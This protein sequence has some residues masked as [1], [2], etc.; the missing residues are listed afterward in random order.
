[1]NHYVTGA[2]IKALREKQDMTQS[3]LAT[4]LCVSDKTISKWETGRGFPDISLIEALAS[5]LQVS[6]PELLS[7][8]QIINTNRS[9]NILRSRIYVCPICGNILHST[10]MALISCCGI[11]LPPLEP[12]SI[13]DG[14]QLNCEKIGH[15]YFVAIE[16]PMSKAHYISFIAY[17]TGDRFEVVKLYP[18]GKS[19]ASFFSRGHGIFYWY[20]N[21]H[22]L[23]SKKI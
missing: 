15:E 2:T 12:E 21:H 1:M 23:F 19:E 3:Q 22:G 9:A 18:E 5:A 20:C 13:D 6:I 4:K 14:H 10:G 7:G 11:T 16:H 17:C 8:E